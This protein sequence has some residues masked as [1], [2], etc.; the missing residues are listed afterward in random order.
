MY[1]CFASQPA[2]MA[3]TTKVGWGRW[4]SGMRCVHVCGIYDANGLKTIRWTCIDRTGGT[5]Q[6]CFDVPPLEEGE[7]EHEGDVGTLNAVSYTIRVSDDRVR[8]DIEDF[9]EVWAEV[10][11]S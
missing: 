5:E 6:I 4:I 8:I 2:A 7:H 1:Q 9:P 10:R 11:K 3:E